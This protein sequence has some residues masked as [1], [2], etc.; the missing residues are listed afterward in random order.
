MVRLKTAYWEFDFEAV[1]PTLD[2]DLLSQVHMSTC[3]STHTKCTIWGM[4]YV[5][6]NASMNMCLRT[7]IFS[8]CLSQP[9]DTHYEPTGGKMCLGASV[10]RQCQ[11]P[12]FLFFKVVFHCC[13]MLPSM[14]DAL[15]FSILDKAGSSLSLADVIVFILASPSTRS[16]QSKAEHFTLS[17]HHCV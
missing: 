1:C 3:T 7:V 5:H 13:K 14:I 12:S 6:A 17:F 2:H 10:W 16:T 4:C 9:T 8:V 11:Q 15:I